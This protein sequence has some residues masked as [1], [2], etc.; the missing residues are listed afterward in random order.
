MDDLGRSIA[1]AIIGIDT[2]P[3]QSLTATQARP[4]GLALKFSSCGADISRGKRCCQILCEVHRGHCPS[5]YRETGGP[6][7]PALIFAFRA[8]YPK[9]DYSSVSP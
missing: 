9:N 8:M 3:P 2:S 7:K 6:S 1:E 5:A 4:A